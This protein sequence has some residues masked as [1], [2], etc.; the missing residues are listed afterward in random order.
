ME[1]LVLIADDLT[2]AG[3]AG[4]TFAR[5]GLRTTLL[6]DNSG[7]DG[8][9][10]KY[11]ALAASSESR[12]MRPD[13]AA[14]AVADLM[15]RC[16]AAGGKYFFKKVDSVMRGNPG[17]ETLAALETLK[18]LSCRAAIV[19]PALPAAGRVVR[20]G[21]L[22]VNGTPI[23]ETPL[24]RD[25]FTPVKTSDVA[26]CFAAGSGVKTGLV[27]RQDLDGGVEAVR[28]R[29]LQLVEQGCVIIASDAESDADLDVLSRLLRSTLPP[30]LP[31]GSSGLARA[32]AGPPTRF[33][34]LP[35]GRLLAVIGSL[36]AIAKEQ[37]DQACDQGFF[38]NL[39]VDIDA[40]L[41]DPE[42]EC[43][44]LLAAAE[45]TSGNVL[46]RGLR[47]PDAARIDP[48]EANRVAELYGNMAARLC[49]DGAFPAVY[50]TGGSTAVAVAKALGIGSLTLESE[51][52]P[53]V[54]LSSCSAPGGVKQFVSKSG[55]FGGPDALVAV[56][57]AFSE[58]NQ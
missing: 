54:V 39:P 12:F 48:G 27:G 1:N 47:R 31:V 29:V 58:K 8:V 41:A 23:H 17:A 3:D 2:G 28:R 14:R 6:L 46:L 20:D 57:S 16:R 34:L 42:Q 21:I 19:C 44:R 10:A 51:I 36:D 53:G 50:A 25:P 38:T 5:S 24:G 15:T 45:K 11:N 9:F 52:L 33:D 56:A 13:D 22:Y 26:E 37:A 18:P 49:K 7:V 32:F 4:V 43:A 55:S 30:L 40:G 35:R